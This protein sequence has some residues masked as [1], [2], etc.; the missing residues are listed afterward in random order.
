MP[1]TLSMKNCFNLVYPFLIFHY[2]KILLGDINKHVQYNNYPIKANLV[3]NQKKK[4]KK[5]CN[6]SQLTCENKKLA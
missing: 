1:M 3:K 6:S 2:I 4:K 5:T